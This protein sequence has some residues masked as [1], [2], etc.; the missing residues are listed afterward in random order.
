MS[1]MG[2]LERTCHMARPV[3]SGFRMTLFPMASLAWAPLQFSR[4]EGSLT[5]TDRSRMPH[6]PPGR[7]DGNG[8]RTHPW[9]FVVFC[10]RS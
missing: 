10:R 3:V 1:Q 4:P 7:S 9:V 8:N 6:L 5:D 2:A